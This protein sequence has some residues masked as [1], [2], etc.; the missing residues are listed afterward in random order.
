MKTV[1]EA[2]TLIKEHSLKPVTE[3][4]TVDGNLVGH[5]LA[6]DIAA[7]EDVPA[8]RASIVDGYAIRIPVSGKFDKGIYPVAFASVAHTGE[9]QELK[10]GQIARITTGAPLPPGS[11]AVVMVE[12]T[13]LK[14]VTDD[15]KEEKE[16]EILTSEIK[17]GENVREIGSDVRKGTIIMRKGDGV[18]AVGGELGL[19]AS[20]GVQQVLVFRKPIV[21][22]LSTGDEIIQ[23]MDVTPG[24]LKFGQVRDTNRPTLMTAIEATGFKA[25]DLGIATDK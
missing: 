9:I 21:G 2:L 4:R 12:D 1:N 19:L 16:V 25:V 18:S 6:E 20:V 8:F 11:S 15:T 22:V 17:E 5:V 23:H 14:S 7:P 10:E 13:A 24:E 3:T